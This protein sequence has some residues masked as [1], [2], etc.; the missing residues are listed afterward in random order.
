MPTYAKETNV[1]SEISRL[2]IEKTLIRYGAANFAYATAAGKAM[3]GFSMYGRQVKF[4]LPLPRKEEFTQTPTGRAR[5]EKSQYDA[6]EQACRQRWRALLL[7]IKAKLEAVECG[8]SVFEQEFMA[9]IM[10]PD[11]GTVGEFMLPQ[12]AQ[13]YETGIMPAM[14]PMLEG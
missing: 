5:T 10:L 8:I 7:V 12:I 13:A 9:N 4:L 2:E 6:W 14:L 1:A 3:I 11:G